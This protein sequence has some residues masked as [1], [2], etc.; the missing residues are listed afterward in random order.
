[1]KILL[2]GI[3]GILGATVAR[4]LDALGH[5]I[6][7]VDNRP[8]PSVPM[9][10]YLCDLAA[11][12]LRLPEVETVDAVIHL[13]NLPNMIGKQ[14]NEVLIQNNAIN[15]N[16][17]HMAAISGVKRVVFASSIQAIAGYEAKWTIQ[18]FPSPRMTYLPLDSN[19]PQNPGS[20]WYALSKVHAELMLENLAMEYPGRTFIAARFPW[21]LTELLHW[22]Y[23][24]DSINHQSYPILNYL[25]GFT[26]LSVTD[27]A[28]FVL[29]CLDSELVGYH[30]Y[31]PS[32]C[33]R[34]SDVS[35]KRVF[36][37]FFASI[38]RRNES[39]LPNT[40]VDI[41]KI[42]D[43]IGWEPLHPQCRVPLE[44]IVAKYFPHLGS[45]IAP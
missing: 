19:M 11:P 8:N 38:P 43:E 21:I 13:A 23:M 1:M 12:N 36:H 40:T 16:V 22:K 17:F 45:A 41:R 2:T 34:F 4:A 24:T 10:V 5:E 31:L 44:P 3:A 18:D 26:Y 20:N 7:A 35:H 42:T 6:I 39:N 14:P 33:F 15:A 28:T 9:R 30:N 27:A 29:K 25:E 32:Q 37:D